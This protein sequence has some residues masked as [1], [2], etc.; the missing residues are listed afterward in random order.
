MSQA[1]FNA[2]ASIKQYEFNTKSNVFDS[3]EVKDEF[4]YSD[5]DFCVGDVEVNEAETGVIAQAYQD[6]FS[7]FD[8]KY[9]NFDDIGTFEDDNG[10]NG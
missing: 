3:Q 8:R 6:E 10:W 7:V 4:D 9:D 2:N 1:F 5:V